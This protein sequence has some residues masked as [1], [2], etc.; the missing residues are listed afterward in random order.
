MKA[1]DSSSL[2]ELSEE[3]LAFL[4]ICFFF[5]GFSDELEGYLLTFL[6]F[7]L[8]VFLYSS[9]KLFFS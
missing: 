4:S 9:I 1:D 3:L 2:E 5:L 7:S 8:S 6:S